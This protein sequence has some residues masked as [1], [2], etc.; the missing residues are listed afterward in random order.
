MLTQITVS[1]PG[2]LMLMGEHA[3][4][5]G[6]PSLV[7]AVDSRFYLTAKILNTPDFTHFKNNA[8]CSTK[9]EQ[10]GRL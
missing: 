3:V 1:A 8:H 10:W 9:A 2:K 6:F 5:Y 4:V 7:T